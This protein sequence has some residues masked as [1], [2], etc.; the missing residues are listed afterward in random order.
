VL[1]SFVQLAQA[2][3]RS[4][5]LLSRHGGE[6][7][8]VLAPDCDHAGAMALAERLRACIAE[9]SFADLAP[10][11]VVT[12]SIGLSSYRLDDTIDTLL[13]RADAALYQA[14]SLGRNRVARLTAPGEH[15]V[16]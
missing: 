3:V 8:A 12:I 6:E 14:K 13:E 9:H 11:L 2:Q 7:F 15:G 5:D 4:I 16:I 10:G 1:R